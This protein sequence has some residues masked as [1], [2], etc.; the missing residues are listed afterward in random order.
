MNKKITKEDVVKKLIASRNRKREH[1]VKLEKEIRT[2]APL[3]SGQL[4]AQADGSTNISHGPSFAYAHQGGQA[5]PCAH[6]AR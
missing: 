4:R 1:L 2:G 3:I 6:G 5:V